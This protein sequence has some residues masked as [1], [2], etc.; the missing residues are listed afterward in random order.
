M[1]AITL[2]NLPPEIARRIQ[3]EAERMGISLNRAVILMLQRALGFDGPQKGKRAHHDLDRFAG[4]WSKQE[5][6]KFE[7]GLSDQRRIDPELWG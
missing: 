3:E 5:A 1:K 6:V 4:T 7:Q 2:R